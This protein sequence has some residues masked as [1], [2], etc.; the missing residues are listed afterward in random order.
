MYIYCLINICICSVIRHDTNH[1]DQG[2]ICKSDCPVMFSKALND[3]N[4]T[5]LLTETHFLSDWHSIE[6]D[7]TYTIS[8]KL[9]A[10]YARV[11]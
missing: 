11:Y 3:L 6:H 8:I 2:L 5:K 1:E 9:S 7:A 4:T 10:E